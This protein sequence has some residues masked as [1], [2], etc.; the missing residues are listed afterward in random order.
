MD[1]QHGYRGYQ[2][3][4]T[5]HRNNRCGT[6]GNAVN[7]DGH[8]ALI[9]HEHIVDLCCRHAVA[10]GRID[11]DGNVPAAAVQLIFKKLRRDIIV[12]PAFLCDGTVQKQR[13]LQR[14]LL[15]FLIRHRPVLPVPELLHRN[16]SPSRW[17]QKYLRL[18]A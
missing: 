14:L 6:G 1:H 3:L 5:C 10:A 18:P 15:S 7:L 17:R 16:C 9:V 2:H 11:P 13:P 12:K 8:I 4:C